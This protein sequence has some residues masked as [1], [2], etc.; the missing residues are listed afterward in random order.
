VE[1]VVTTASAI[2]LA[3]REGVEMPIAEMVYR[4]L[5]DHHPAR[6]AA[7]ELMKRELRAEQD[8]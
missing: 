8:E 3:T 6:L 7:Q 4:I 5:F 1:G 2:E